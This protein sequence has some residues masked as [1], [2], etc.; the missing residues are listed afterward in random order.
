[1]STGADHYREA[2]RL[3]G[4]ASAQ[5]APEARAV[6]AAA[7]V[8]ATL[9]HAAAVL[10]GAMT[11]PKSAKSVADI[12]LHPVDWPPLPGDIWTDKHGRRWA[13]QHP[14][15]FG[16][17]DGAGAAKSYLVCLAEPGDDHADEIYRRHGPLRLTYRPKPDA[18]D[19]ES[20]F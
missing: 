16:S 9:A 4:V 17:W 19:D 13:C 7:L 1:M 10:V 5:P 15:C 2:E 6:Y 8:H 14:A 12:D 20:S 11:G 18:R 3:L